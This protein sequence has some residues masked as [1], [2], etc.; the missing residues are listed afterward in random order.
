MKKIIL[1][2]HYK[3]LKNLVSNLDLDPRLVL[4]AERVF[5]F[6]FEIDDGRVITVSKSRESSKIEIDTE[7]LLID[8]TARTLKKPRCTEN[9]IFDALKSGEESNCVPVFESDVIEVRYYKNR[10]EA[11]DKN[12]TS[13]ILD[14]IFIKNGTCA[15]VGLRDE[16]VFL[17]SIL[18]ENKLSMEYFRHTKNGENS[19]IESIDASDTSKEKNVKYSY[20]ART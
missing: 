16:A 1:K 18:D 4:E 17:E 12:F 6:M 19:I 2:F 9:D 11:Q 8:T 14:R 20:F 7:E 3:S 15:R 13:P 10:A 5:S